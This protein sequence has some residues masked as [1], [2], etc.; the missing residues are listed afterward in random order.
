MSRIEV[1][2]DRLVLAGI[3]RP[4]RDAFV[5][6]A[7]RSTRAHALG[8]RRVPT[9]RTSDAGAA[10][11]AGLTARAGGAPVRAT[12]SAAASDARSERNQAMSTGFPA[13]AEAHKRRHRHDGPRHVRGAERDL[14]AVQPGFADPDAA[15]SGA[16]G[17]A[18]RRA[19]R[20]AAPARPGDR[21]HQARGRAR[22][23][24][25]AR[26][27]QPVSARRAVRPAA[28]ARAAGD[29]GQPDRRDAAGRRRAWRTP[30]RSRSFRW[31]SR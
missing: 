27:S 19:G 23:H 15:D 25:P 12:G 24:R 14:A 13:V 31:S 29:A 7:P 17:R 21:D 9:A 18:G 5:T 3:D 28:A 16:A 26:V 10:A 22:R 4:G 30:A 2:I 20:C 1:M 8:R 11:S 6:G